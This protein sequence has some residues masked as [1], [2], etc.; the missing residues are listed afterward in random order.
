[1]VGDVVKEKTGI[2][3]RRETVLFEKRT[4]SR[5]HPRKIL[6]HNGDVGTKKIYLCEGIWRETVL[7]SKRMVSR[8]I[9]R[10]IRKGVADKAAEKGK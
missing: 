6:I 5:T 1:M 8:F 9:S 2:Y 3:N 7:F 4:V 10:F